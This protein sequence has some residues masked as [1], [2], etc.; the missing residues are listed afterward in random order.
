MRIETP[1][2]FLPRTGQTTSYATGDDGDLQ[3]GN[4]RATRFVDN[5][6]GTVTDRATGL[7]WVQDPTDCGET[8]YTGGALVTMN[9]ADAL[10]ACNGLSYA[11]FDDWRLPNIAEL[12]SL[13]LRNGAPPPIDPIF[14]NAVTGDHYWSSTT[15]LPAATY[16]YRVTHNASGY[17]YT[18]GNLKTAAHYVRPV[19]GGRING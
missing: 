13:L 7:Q 9:W 6:N 4:P 17:G 5:G 8:F 14:T 10:A 12:A 18:G 16:A 2:L 15:Y 1:K 3:A 19:R 11:G